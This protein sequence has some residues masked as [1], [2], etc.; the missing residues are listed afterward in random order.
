ME[1][2]YFIPLSTLSSEE[3]NKTTLPTNT[4]PLL[5]DTLANKAPPAQCFQTQA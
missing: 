1:M 4:I 3:N 2:L 5:R